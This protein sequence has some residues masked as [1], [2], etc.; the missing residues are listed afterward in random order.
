MAGSERRK[1]GLLLAGV[2]AGWVVACFFAVAL[3]SAAVGMLAQVIGRPGLATNTVFTVA[4]EALVHLLLAVVI[5]GLA[6]ASAPPR[7]FWVVGPVG[8]LVAF[9]LFLA[10]ML[11]LG[12]TNA[13][14]R[15]AGWAF[16]VGDVVA[17]ALGAWAV[18]RRPAIAGPGEA[19]EPTGSADPASPEAPE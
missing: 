12:N 9:G 6:R 11:L 16:V 19:A 8:Y 17:T 4:V 10:F 15:G 13:V 14:P 3:V 5:F 2:A 7:W 18:L 1:N